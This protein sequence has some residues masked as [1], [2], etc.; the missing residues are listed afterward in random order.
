MWVY[1]TIKKWKFKEKSYIKFVI[2]LYDVF[3]INLQKVR[4]CFVKLLYIQVLFPGE[5][6]ISSPRA[7]NFYCFKTILDR[8]IY[9]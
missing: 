9:K 5:G 2:K 8:I 4:I 6:V 3:V 7:F 1:E